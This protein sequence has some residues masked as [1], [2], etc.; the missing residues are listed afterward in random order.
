V[1]IL[2]LDGHV[3]KAV[4]MLLVVAVL[5]VGMTV[6]AV[7][8]VFV[9][10]IVFRVHNNLSKFKSQL[11]NFKFDE[12]VKNL[13]SHRSHKRRREL[14]WILGVTFALSVHFVANLD[15]LRFH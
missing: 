6:S 15:L 4:L 1:F 11:P 8:L 13:F 14:L 3:D 7:L 5:V 10:V 12:F 2:E 9:R